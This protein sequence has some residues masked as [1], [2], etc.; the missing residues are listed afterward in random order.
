MAVMPWDRSPESTDVTESSESQST[1]SLAMRMLEAGLPLTLLLDLSA[2]EGPESAL[3]IAREGSGG[4][5]A[6][7]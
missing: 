1:P 7:G 6:L 4:L 3:I 2:K 5:A